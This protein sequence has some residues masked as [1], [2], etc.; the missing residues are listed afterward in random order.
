MAAPTL[1]TREQWLDTGLRLLADGG[2]EAV[3]VEAVA[4]RLG[5]TKGGFYGQFKD[6]QVYLTALLD[7]WEQ[8]VTDAVRSRVEEQ[9]GAASRRLRQAGLLTFAEDLLLPVE[10]AVRD[11]ARRD[12][13]VAAR[14]RR[15]DNSRMEYLRELIGSTVAD[16]VEVEA[17]CLLA[18][19]LAIGR[20]LL[21]ADTDSSHRAQ[22]LA[23]A[24]DLVDPA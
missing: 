18:Y 3:R 15:V 4:R 6:R 5:V 16:P 20:H 10:L 21:A 13:A 22:A 14:I 17:R 2:P 23:K 1:T 9:G 7:D 11:W 24:I 19:C 12:L 8:R